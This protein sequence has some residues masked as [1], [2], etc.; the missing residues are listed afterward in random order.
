MFLGQQ[1]EFGKMKLQILGSNE[2][3]ETEFPLEATYL[4]V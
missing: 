2:T 4:Y 1:A 3:F